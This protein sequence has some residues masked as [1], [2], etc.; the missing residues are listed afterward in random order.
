MRKSLY[1]TSWGIA[2]LFS[3]VAVPFFTPTINALEFPFLHIIA[4]TYFLFRFLKPSNECEMV[5]HVV[6]ICIPWWLM[7]CV[8]SCGGWPFVELLWRNVQVV[9][10][11]FLSVLLAFLLLNCRSCFYILDTRSFLDI[12]LADF[13]FLDCPFTFLIMSFNAHKFLILMK[14]NSPIF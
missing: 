10:P 7:M 3:T 11:F 1:W 6:L 5:S 14:L 9:Y 4:D 8:F 13:H 12:W 2:K